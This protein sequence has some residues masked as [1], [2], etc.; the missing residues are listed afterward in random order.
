MTNGNQSVVAPFGQSG[1]FLMES[2][3]TC[4]QVGSTVYKT[5][6]LIAKNNLGVTIVTSS[7]SASVW[8]TRSN[9]TS[10]VSGASV[11]LYSVLNG[12][13]GPTPTNVNVLSTATTDSNGLAILQVPASAGTYVPA[14]VAV[15]SGGKISL[16][17][18]I[19]FSNQPPTLPSSVQGTLITDR[20]FYA[21][22][23]TIYI[24]AYIRYLVQG[25]LQLPGPEQWALSIMWSTADP[26]PTT[27][28]G[29]SVDPTYGTFQY[30]LTIPSDADSGTLYLSAAT[31]TQPSS[32][33]FIPTLSTTI[34]IAQPRIPTVQMTLN[35]SSEIYDLGNSSA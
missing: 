32:L 5:A 6:S 12:I 24:K 14:V 31:G 28:P 3:L 16:S 17:N 19:F 34:L 29:I 23:D 33:N 4:Y 13:N 2:W 9:T 21:P 22:G 26:G 20:G 25:T 11:T 27:Y 18:Q 15:V 10:V 7:N 8:V 35:S 30:T 1:L